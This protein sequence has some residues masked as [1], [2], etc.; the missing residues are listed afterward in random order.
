MSESIWMGLEP[1]PTSTRVLVMRSASETILKAQLSLRPSSPHAVVSLMEA[2]ALWE[3]RQVRAAL[4]VADD[5][6]SLSTSVYRDAFEI[7]G[8]TSALYELEWV[9]RAARARRRRDGL[10]GLGDFRELERLLV[11]A[12]AR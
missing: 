10:D 8:E 12:V 2:L 7:H 3:G 9:P 4:V 11:T 5:S 1:G 6:S